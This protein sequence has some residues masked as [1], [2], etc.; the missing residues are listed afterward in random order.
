MST[1]FH[2][3][4]PAAVFDPERY[5]KVEL[6]RGT[7]LFVGLNCLEAGQEQ[8]VHVHQG[9]DKFYLVLSGKARIR[10][11]DEVQVAGAGTIA[12][13]PAGIAHGVEEALERTVLLVGMAP[14]PGRT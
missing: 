1:Y 7:T 3:T 4:A 10:V 11:G 13:A 5:A 2:P 8:P 12:W 14:P 6:A 9:A